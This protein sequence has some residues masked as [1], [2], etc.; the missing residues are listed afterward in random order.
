MNKTTQSKFL[1][2]RPGAYLMVLLTAL[3]LGPGL[4]VFGFLFYLQSGELTRVSRIVEEQARQNHLYSTLTFYRFGVYKHELYKRLSREKDIKVIALG[5]SRVWQVVPQSFDEPFISL[6]SMVF[7]VEQAAYAVDAIYETHPPELVLFGID[8]WWFDED[9]VEPLRFYGPQVHEPRF[10]PPPSEYLQPWKWLAQGKL[11]PAKFVSVILGGD[12]NTGIAAI[13]SGDGF[14][15]DGVPVFTREVSGAIDVKDAGFEASMKN[16]ARGAGNFPHGE[17]VSAER[18]RKFMDVLATMK[19]RGTEV[20]LF[21]PPI[22]PTVYEKMME[23]GEFGYIDDL[24]RRLRAQDVFEFYDYTDPATIGATDCEF[25]D[26]LHGGTIVYRRVL[27]DMAQKTQTS[28]PRRLDMTEIGDAIA[29]SAG[30]V[31]HPHE[32][33]ADFLRLGCDK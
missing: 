11:S 28:L 20:V 2:P 30:Y 25:R 27:R 9:Y 31:T 7:G 24:V 17:E 1:E 13:V 4:M 6:G 23:S 26:G 15:R 8:Y 10:A 19:A 22:A 21:L 5:S 16:I 3:L 14:N 29:R 12:E 33:E 18:W 32:G